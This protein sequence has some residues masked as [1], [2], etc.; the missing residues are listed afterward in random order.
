MKVLGN[1]NI[2]DT[3]KWHNNSAGELLR[4]RAI[5]LEQKEKKS[6][7]KQSNT[8]ACNAAKPSLNINTHDEQNPRNAQREICSTSYEGGHL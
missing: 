4:T 8:G 1:A 3:K 5:N 2:Q 6:N 7:N